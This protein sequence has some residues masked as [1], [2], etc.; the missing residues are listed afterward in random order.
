VVL[1]S[2]LVLVLALVGSGVIVVR[3]YQE[4]LVE[5]HQACLESIARMEPELFPDLPKELAWVEKKMSPYDEIVRTAW[6]VSEPSEIQYMGPGKPS[7][8][9]EPITYQD[10]IGRWSSE[11]AL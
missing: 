9:A 3:S 8:K 10:V 2:C 5:R 6:L 7:A 11:E 1:L 4:G